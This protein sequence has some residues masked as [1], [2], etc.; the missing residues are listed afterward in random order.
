MTESDAT[1]T[2][3]WW[4][5]HAPVT[6]FT[7]KIYG[8]LD[9]PADCSESEL[10][11]GL[12]RTLPRDAVWVASNLRRTH[13]TAEAIE[14]A[15]LELPTL[16]IEPDL[17]E[18]SFGDWQGCTH[19]D[20][21]ALRG[22]DWHRFWLAPAHQRPPGGESFADLVDRAARAI[23]RLTREHRGRDIVA[24]AHGGT[25]RAAVAVAMGLEAERALALAVDNCSLTR[26]DHID[27]PL[28]SAS[29]ASD[30]GVWRVCHLNVPPRTLT[31]AR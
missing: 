1:V 28:S 25:I 27:G 9:V 10:F 23:D 2:R 16:V 17:A 12:A 8:Q 30:E 13:D 20:L 5:R 6:C 18:Q 14:K 24:V 3:W 4:I 22:N 21:A 15:G 26:L 7:G 19:Q 11:P 31:A 29:E